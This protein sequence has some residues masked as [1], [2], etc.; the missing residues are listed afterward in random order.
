MRHATIFS[1]RVALIVWGAVFVGLVGC[2]QAGDPPGHDAAKSQGEKK[3][4]KV[5]STAF[6]EGQV[7]PKKY[8]G[9]GA[10][11][12]PPLAWSGVPDGTKALALICDDPDAPRPEPWV[13]WVIYN[14]PPDAKGLPEG[15]PRRREVEG[16][17]RRAARRQL[18]ACHGIPRAE[19]ARGTRRA[20]LLL[21]ALRVGQ[22]T[23][24]NARAGQE[25]AAEG[26]AGSQTG[27][28]R[29]HR[30]VRTVASR[31]AGGLSAWQEWKLLRH[32]GQHRE[33]P[34][35]D[36]PYPAS[37]AAATTGRRIR[38]DQPG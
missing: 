35:R 24:G 30:D 38:H 1:C 37:S 36:D 29:A 6:A 8:T 19:A 34:A 5:T 20:S 32:G 33:L 16:A 27:Q 17:Q 22:A 13:H 3:M 12:S 28:R 10:D 18:L 2:S 11:V 15:V 25:N 14:I 26:D 7:I 9:D 23:A 4:I 21:Q 31:V